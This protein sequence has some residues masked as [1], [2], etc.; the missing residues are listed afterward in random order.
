MK[1]TILTS[2]LVLILNIGTAQ[3]FYLGA[4]D[5]SGDA[6]DISSPDAKSIYH[7]I[8]YT[9]DSLRFKMEFYT[10]VDNQEWNVKI[11]ID[12]NNNVTDGADW[13]G[14]STALKYDLLVDVYSNPN[15]PPVLG[16]IID[17]N[18][19]YVSSNVSVTFPDTNIVII[20]LLLFD[21][22]QNG[23]GLN[24]VT[25]TGIIIGSVNDELPESNYIS[26]SA[27]LETT[28]FL[29][30]DQVFV[31]PNPV[32]ENLQIQVPSHLAESQYIIRDLHGRVSMSGTLNSLNDGIH[33]ESLVSGIYFLSISNTGFEVTKKLAKL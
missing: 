29:S 18:G 8:D 22:M 3:T 6:T 5:V 11:A 13:Q 21:F 28:H 9:E 33:V 31:Y 14:A 32:N 26:I 25:G 30:D 17:A 12:T 20:S 27:S 19:N 2:V 1:A 23:V 24:Y 4:N 10:R 16:N 15:F 7:S